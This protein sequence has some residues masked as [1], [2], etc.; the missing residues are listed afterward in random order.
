[1]RF[2]KHNLTL[3]ELVITLAVLAA[4]TAAVFSMGT[5]SIDKIRYDR[6]IREGRNI[7]SAVWNDEPGGHCFLSDMGR[8]PQFSPA[9]SAK[10]GATL[11]E[12]FDYNTMKNVGSREIKLNKNEILGH[13]MG[14]PRVKDIDLNWVNGNWNNIIPDIKITCGWN[15]PYI[16][17][18]SN[19][20]L[21]G[22][23]REWLMLGNDGKYD[24]APKTEKEIWGLRSYGSDNQYQVS[25]TILTDNKSPFSEDIIFPFIT[26]GLPDGDKPNPPATLIINLLCEDRLSPNHSISA[27]EFVDPLT[28]TK[29]EKRDPQKTYLLGSLIKEDGVVYR[30]TAVCGEPATSGGY[31]VSVTPPVFGYD[32][33]TMYQ[34]SQI[35]WERHI[36]APKH[37]NNFLIAQVTPFVST[38][39]A[40]VRSNLSMIRYE[41]DANYENSIHVT[42]IGNGPKCTR[43]GLNRYIYEGLL[44]GKRKIFAVAYYTT[45]GEINGY[46]ALNILQSEITEVN[47]KPGVNEITLILRSKE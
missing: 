25:G 7:Q 21:D 1:M 41:A 37:V 40:S 28:L 5:E 29:I 35:L 20:Q 11:N 27:P 47:I 19:K 46:M 10:S 26:P 2:F 38:D 36:P 15:G 16:T 4:L 12:L 23:G 44:P 14:T 17:S 31:P 13:L 22:W 9:F 45:T 34:D 8:L 3:L 30:C 39:R 42:A 32:W 6:T 33:R 43:T 18:F 24:V